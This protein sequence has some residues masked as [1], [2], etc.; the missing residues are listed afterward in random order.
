MGFYFVVLVC[1][2]RYTTVA[3]EISAE[4]YHTCSRLDNGNVKCWGYGLYGRLGQG[5]TDNIGDGSNGKNDNPATLG[6]N[7]SLDVILDNVNQVVLCEKGN[8]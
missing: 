8:Q 4:E 6:I 2:L 3:L 5:N 7:C 1:L